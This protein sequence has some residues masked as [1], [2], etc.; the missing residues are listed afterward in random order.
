MCKAQDKMYSAKDN[1]PFCQSTRQ[2]LFKKESRFQMQ[3][4]QR[5]Q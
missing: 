1:T 3:N 5:D 2:K 4:M